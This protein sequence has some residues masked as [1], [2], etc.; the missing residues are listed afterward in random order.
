MKCF[1]KQQNDFYDDLSDS[2]G[3]NAKPK[4]LNSF[5]SSEE[6]VILNASFDKFKKNVTKANMIVQVT[7]ILCF[8]V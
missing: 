7:N 2:S 1:V 4:S 8:Q 5:D 6:I 3:E